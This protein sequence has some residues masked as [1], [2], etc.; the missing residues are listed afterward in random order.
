MAKKTTSTV[1]VVMAGDDVV[2]VHVEGGPPDVGVVHRLARLTLRLKRPRLVR[3]T[4]SEP[5]ASSASC[6]SSAACPISS[7]RAT[8][9]RL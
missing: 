7:R 5:P 9:L 4:S 6:S 3:S 2:V 8:R 1:V